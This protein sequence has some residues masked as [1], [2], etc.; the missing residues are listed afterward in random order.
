M[1]A[2]EEIL[3]VLSQDFEDRHVR[4]PSQAVPDDLVDIVVTAF[5]VGDEA[6]GVILEHVK[7]GGFAVRPGIDWLARQ[8]Q[9]IRQVPVRYGILAAE[10]VRDIG[11]TADGVCLRNGGAQL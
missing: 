5:R 1:T 3:A 11:I 4:V 10:T 6:D 8:G 7:N 2:T 9:P